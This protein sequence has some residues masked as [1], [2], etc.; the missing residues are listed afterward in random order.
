MVDHCGFDKLHIDDRSVTRF[1]LPVHF[2]IPGAGIP[3]S[4]R[5][6]KA[7]LPVPEELKQKKGLN[8]NFLFPIPE[9]TRTALKSGDDRNT[10]AP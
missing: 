1:Q 4:Y 3:V 9:K 10:M 8:Y 6:R 2:S 7:K 5:H